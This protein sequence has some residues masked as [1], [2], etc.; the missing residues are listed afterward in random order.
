M[1]LAL[2]WCTK[3]TC[4]RVYSIKKAVLYSET[5]APLQAGMW[6]KKIF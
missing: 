6:W 5:L 4:M 1:R 2:D 3:R